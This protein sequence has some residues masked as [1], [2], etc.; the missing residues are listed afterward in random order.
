MME[1]TLIVWLVIMLVGVVAVAMIEMKSGY[2]GESSCLPGCMTI[3][4]LGCLVWLAG[5]LMAG[6]FVIQITGG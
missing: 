2:M 3:A 5:C 6:K 4:V 1:W